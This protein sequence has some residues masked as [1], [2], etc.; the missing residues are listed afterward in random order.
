RSGFEQALRGF[1]IALPSREHEGRQSSASASNKTGNNDIR[2]IF[3]FSRS[4]LNSLPCLSTRTAAPLIE[5]VLNRL[6]QSIHIDACRQLTGERGNSFERIG[7]EL[8]TE[9]DN[10]PRDRLNIR[11]AATGLCPASRLSA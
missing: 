10:L 4:S 3:V 1:H 11:S 6:G 9:L 7:A 2:I 5:N 8:A